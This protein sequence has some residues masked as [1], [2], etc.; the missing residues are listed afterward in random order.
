MQ[1]IYPAMLLLLSV[2][3]VSSESYAQDELPVLEG[4]YLGQKPPGT[5]PEVFAPGIVST[6]GWEYG[7]VFAPNMKE[8]YFIREVD[9]ETNPKQEF[10]VFESK[11]NRWHERVISL[12]V[13]TPAFSPD[14][15]IMHLGRRYKERTVSGW[16]ERKSLGSPFEEIRIMRMTSSSKGTYTFDEIGPDNGNSILR[17]SRLVDGERE[18]PKPFPE[19]INTGKYN[20]HPFIAPDES[21][22]IWD[23][24]RDSDVRNA[25]LFISFKKSNGSWGEAI[26]MGEKINTEASEFAAQVTPD[27]KYLFFNRN[28]GPDN[29]DTFWINA[30]VIEDLRPRP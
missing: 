4:S 18:T 19:E 3:A 5:T 1:S 27:G 25:D 17:F 16:S 24:Q 7:V 15:K 29:T 9:A 6:K 28:V 13:G 12:R 2:M 21:Y 30:Q 11:N 20:A 10:V 23:G 14:G 22:L 26:K 8:I